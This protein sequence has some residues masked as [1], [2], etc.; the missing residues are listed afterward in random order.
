MNQLPFD[1]KIAENSL[2]VSNRDTSMYKKNLVKVTISLEECRIFTFNF[3][4]AL[5]CV[6]GHDKKN[7]SNLFGVGKKC[8]EFESSF[9]P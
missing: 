9:A 7:V 2:M 6:I 5:C 4:V 3:R 8:S 1:A